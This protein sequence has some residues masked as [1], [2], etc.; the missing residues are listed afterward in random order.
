MTRWRA[1]LALLGGLAFATVSLGN[2]LHKG[3]DFDVFVDA[4]QRVL[5]GRPLYTD[6]TP[7]NGVIGPP[8]QGVFFAPSGW[9]ARVS[10]ALAKVTW[11]LVNLA[12]LAAGCWLWRLA[13]ADQI[14]D[15]SVASTPM[16]LAI[17]A[18][19]LPAQTNFEHQN[20]N[21]LL[22]ALCGA[23]AFALTRS[24]PIRGGVWFGVAAALKVF[25]GFVLAYLLARRE[26]RAAVAGVAT[27]GVLTLLPAVRYGGAAFH[28]VGDWLAIH[29]AGDWPTRLQNQ[30]IYAAVHRAWPDHA[31][32]VVAGV[33]AVLVLLVLAVAMPRRRQHV[34]AEELAMVLAA[35][36]LLSPIAWDHY[37][38]LMFPAVLAVAAAR[39]RP[40]WVTCAV[41]A[42]LITGPS[43]ILIGTHGFNVARAYSLYTFAGVMLFAVLVT[44]GLVPPR[45]AA[46]H[47]R[48]QPQ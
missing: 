1:A 31:N 8:F 23:G 33:S 4:G 20:M 45:A 6:T 11:C 13:C 16:V 9:L 44:R 3:G 10:P 18:I 42:A 36:V 38:V 32:A 21:P 17:V 25:P 47:D 40:A 22:L 19:V 46:P 26:W 14:L 39:S 30:S 2:A 43:P 24:R 29:G 37:W 35:A 7:A 28:L 27:A 12:A 5:D 34:R 41:A 48:S 15:S